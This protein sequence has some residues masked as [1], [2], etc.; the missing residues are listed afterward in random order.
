ME[1]TGE[2]IFIL[3]LSLYIVQKC[4]LPVTHVVAGEAFVH[5]SYMACTPE[6]GSE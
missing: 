6:N 3:K 2:H 1:Q 4:R 5:R